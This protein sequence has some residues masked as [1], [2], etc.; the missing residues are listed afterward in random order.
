[1]PL[2]LRKQRISWAP[3]E[4]GWQQAQGVDCASLLCPRGAP[5][6]VLRPGLGPHYKKDREL[7]ERVQRRATKMI[8]GNEH[9]PYEDRLREVGLSTVEKRKLH[10]DVIAA[11]H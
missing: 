2:Q 6:A 4:E 5:S 7:L 11:F 9:L 8:G 1:M 3:S 10:S